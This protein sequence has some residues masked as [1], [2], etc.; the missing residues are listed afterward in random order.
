MSHEYKKNYL[1]QVIF[2][3]DFENASL[4]GFE[5]MKELLAGEFDIAK[6][7]QG[8]S[9]NFEIKFDS[10]EVINSTEEIEVWQFTNSKTKNKFEIGPTHCL[11]EYFAY[12]NSDDL[13]KH[14]NTYCEELLEKNN[15]S[16]LLRVGLRYINEIDISAIKKISDWNTYIATDLISYINFLKSNNKIATRMLN[17]I[18]TKTDDFNTVF[19]YGIWNNKYPSPITNSPFVL[20]ID[21]FT[22]LAVDFSKGE[23]LRITSELNKE[24]ENIFELSIT[25]KLRKE[26]DK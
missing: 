24:I 12:K 4:S 1:K 5:E 22:R 10:N 25:D 8:R 19:K 13:K 23:L 17:Q 11:L 14:I 7:L 3:V 26:M 2:R 21:G 20:D 18:E 9:G 15:V 16:N 6:K